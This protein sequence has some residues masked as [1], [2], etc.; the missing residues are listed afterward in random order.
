VSLQE[1]LD[2]GQIA[3]EMRDR[4]QRQCRERYK[5]YLAPDLKCASWTPAED[6]T[7]RDR[8][9]EYGPKW[10]AIAT[11]FEER[12][13]VSVKNRWAVIKSRRVKASHIEIVPRIEKPAPE[14]APAPDSA[15]VA[16]ESGG[17]SVIDM[18]WQT[19]GAGWLE[20]D[21]AM[22]SGFWLESRFRNFGSNV[23]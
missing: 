14:S 13:D 23:W 16:T 6:Q 3:A 22:Q 10:A 4:T 1:E 5:N 18:F 8:V 12:S 15:A 2:W 21:P 11:F 17:Q 9:A 20:T 7:L 19:A